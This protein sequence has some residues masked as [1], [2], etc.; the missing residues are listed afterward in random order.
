MAKSL[1]I[2]TEYTS[3]S[4][5]LQYDLFHGNIQN[6]NTKMYLS[7]DMKYAMDKG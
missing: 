1:F 7:S 4:I 6:K 5:K 2:I 3:K